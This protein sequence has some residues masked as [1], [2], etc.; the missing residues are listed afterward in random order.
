[1]AG[2]EIAVSFIFAPGSFSVLG[3]RE[4]MVPSCLVYAK[5]ER[6]TWAKSFCEQLIQI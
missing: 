3:P 6:P 5:N 2:A 4:H 1:M